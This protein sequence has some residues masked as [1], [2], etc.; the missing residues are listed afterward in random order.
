MQA[1][2][3]RQR[4]IGVTQGW[5]ERERIALVA[6]LTRRGLI[7]T[8]AAAGIVAGIPASLRAQTAVA[9]GGTIDF[10]YLDLA[11]EVPADPRRVVVVEGRGDLEFATI[12]GYP[13]I[14]SGNTFWPEEQPGSR[15]D[16]LVSPDLVTLD[17]EN[18]VEIDL[19]QLVGL[20]PDLIVM[21]ANGYRGNWYDN[22]RVAAVAPI[23]AVEVNRG[24]WRE[25]LEAQAAILGRSPAIVPFLA[26]YDDRLVSARAEAEPLFAGRS[27][28]FLTA[29][30]SDEI[31]IWTNDF[32]CAVAT[33]LGMTVPLF[34]HEND[35]LRV[36]PE[37]LDILADADLLIRQV[38]SEENRA[39][40]DGLATWQALPAVK[41]GHVHDI[42]AQ[43]NN[44]LAITARLLLEELV[45]ACRLLGR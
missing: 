43:F 22:D 12:V 23:L 16:G 31:P 34:G 21:R 14:A 17:V 19:E 9:T 44:G 20:K 4:A 2:P 42:S 13:V 25:D 15:L 5:S 18:G 11:F 38:A 36:S 45:A 27:V 33:D 3:D 30:A 37:Q 26:A 28:A 39:A 40:I 6:A 1:A 8:T 35:A 41:A 32:A 29:V 24:T 10:T 7:G